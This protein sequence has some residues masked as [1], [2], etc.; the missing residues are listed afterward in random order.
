MAPVITSLTTTGKLGDTFSIT[1]TGFGVYPGIICLFPDSDGGFLPLVPNVWIDTSIT[2]TIPTSQTASGMTGFFLVV[3]LDS[4][5][6]VKSP[7]FA[8]LPP[9]ITPQEY[10]VSGQLV[11]AAGGT[12]GTSEG[13]GTVVV[14]GTGQGGEAVGQ[15]QTLSEVGANYYTVAWVEDVTSASPT[16]TNIVVAGTSLFVRGALTVAQQVAQ[17]NQ[18]YGSQGGRRIT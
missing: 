11:S 7:D 2:G 10:F 17:G 18:Y 3:P 12:T 13:G 14:P 16:T 1:G 6:G 15:V 5:A 4:E 9:L 8:I